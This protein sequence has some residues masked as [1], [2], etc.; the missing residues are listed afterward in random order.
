MIAFSATLTCDRCGKRA[1]GKIVL[2]SIRPMLGMHVETMPGWKLS[3]KPSGEV[4]VTCP[5]CPPPLAEEFFEEIEIG[6]ADTLTP[7]PGGSGEHRRKSVAPPLP[8]K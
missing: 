2:T 1:T 5:V 4:F 3:S 6:T 7:P 8:R